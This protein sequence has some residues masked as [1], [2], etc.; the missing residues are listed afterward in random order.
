M[1]RVRMSLRLVGYVASVLIIF[2]MVLPCEARRVD[3]TESADAVTSHSQVLEK[4]FLLAVMEE[5]DA[6][7]RT[8]LP[9]EQR[10]ALQTYLKNKVPLLVRSYREEGVVTA[11]DGSRTTTV[12]TTI[13]LPQLIQYLKDAGVYYT[14]GTTLPATFTIMGDAKQREE[15]QQ[16]ALLAGIRQEADSILRFS[17]SPSGKGWYGTLD[18]I[19]HQAAA[20]GATI[21]DVWKALWPA[22]FAKRVKPISGVVESMTLRGWGWQTPDSATLFDRTLREWTQVLSDVKLENYM[23]RPSGVAGTWYVDV[24]NKSALERKL[25]DYAKSRKLRFELAVKP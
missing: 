15:V 17:L 10:A 19:D 7:L 14:A 12:D 6:V 21:A 25:Q 11:E 20:S 16:R 2:A 24:T 3:I 5:S 22:Y 13:N 18:D 4:A 23:L 1:N 9:A 8:V